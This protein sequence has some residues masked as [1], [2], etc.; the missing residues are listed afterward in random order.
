M[1][2]DDVDDIKLGNEGVDRIY[3]STEVVWEKGGLKPPL[4]VTER[5]YGKTP[6][7]PTVYKDFSWTHRGEID[8]EFY[9]M[10]YYPQSDSQNV[11]VK[12]YTPDTFYSKL[13]FI[14]LIKLFCI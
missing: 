7:A 8:A 5:E 4:L 6:M 9:Y 12:Q 3:L 1:K 14:C 10:Y 13:Y 11:T 2:L